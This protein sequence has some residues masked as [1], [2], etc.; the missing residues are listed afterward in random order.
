MKLN[1]IRVVYH[2]KTKRFRLTP[3]PRTKHFQRFFLYF[4]KKQVLLTILLLFLIK[5][6]KVLVINITIYIILLFITL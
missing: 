1:C 3:G 6:T 5:L 4:N 2:L